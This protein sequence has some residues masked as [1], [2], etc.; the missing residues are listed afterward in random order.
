[1]PLSGANDWL[2]GSEPGGFV[3]RPMI[4]ERPSGVV[5]TSCVLLHCTMSSIVATNMASF[6][7]AFVEAMSI[8]PCR[9]VD[10]WTG[11]PP[12]W[13][14]HALSRS[15]G[16]GRAT[17]SSASEVGHWYGAD[18]VNDGAVSKHFLS[19]KRLAAR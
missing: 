13:L 16:G 7:S 11:T 4:T 15:E 2:A 14:A 9:R 3:V 17:W 10:G 19:R 8:V 1:M 5:Q 18:A 12:R 6:R